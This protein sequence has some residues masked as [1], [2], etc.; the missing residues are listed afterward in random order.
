MPVPF[1]KLEL[2]AGE[3][4]SYGGFTHNDIRPYDHIEIVGDARHLTIPPATVTIIRAIHLLEHFSLREGREALRTWWGWL[5]PEGILE[6]AMPDLGGIIRRYDREEIG[7]KAVLRDVYGLA[8]LRE[9]LD[10][11]A[12]GYTFLAMAA[13][14]NGGTLSFSEW[15]ALMS[16]LYQGVPRTQGEGIIKGI[17]AGLDPD[18]PN[19][20]RWG[21]CALSLSRELEEAGFH[22]VHVQSE[23]TSL[24][25]WAVKEVGRRT[26]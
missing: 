23:E 3:S 4:P 7:L 20:H 15:N 14:L 16:Y 19:Y 10:I 25:A 2:G 18:F 6:L 22:R 12:T 26:G 8:P 13:K 1:T 11:I 21:F 5:A 9:G 17:L 24:H